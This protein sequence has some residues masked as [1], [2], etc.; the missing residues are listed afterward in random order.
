LLRNV[1]LRHALTRDFVL[2]LV[3][4]IFLVPLLLLY[5]IIKSLLVIVVP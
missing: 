1:S 5:P 2:Y 3:G 4:F